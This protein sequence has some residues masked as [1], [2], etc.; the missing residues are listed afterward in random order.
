MSFI[1]KTM[2]AL[3]A[4]KTRKAEIDNAPELNVTADRMRD[5]TDKTTIRLKLE[6]Q[7]AVR[8]KLPAILKNIKKHS[9][10]KIEKYYAI[11][12]DILL[13]TKKE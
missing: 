13:V 5:N 12:V 8:D 1:K 4:I 2:K 7:K 6:E 9:K 10:E 3:D 11:R